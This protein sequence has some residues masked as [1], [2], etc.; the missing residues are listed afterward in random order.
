MGFLL[1]LRGSVHSKGALTRIEKGEIKGPGSVVH[2]T[3]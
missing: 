1:A 3:E 2:P